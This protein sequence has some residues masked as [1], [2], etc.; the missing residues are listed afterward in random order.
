MGFDEYIARKVSASRDLTEL[1]KQALAAIGHVHDKHLVHWDLKGANLLIGREGVVKLMDLGNARA[2]SAEPHKARDSARTTRKNLPPELQRRASADHPSAA[3]ESSNRVTV[4]FEN[5]ENSWDLPA[6]DLYCFAREVNRLIGSH[7]P[8]L[9]LDVGVMDGDA[10]A[11]AVQGRASLRKRLAETDEGEYAMRFV[12]LVLRRILESQGR[13]LSSFYLDAGGVQ[14]TVARLTPAFGA[15]DAIPELQVVPQHVARVPPE[16]NIPWT[17]RVNQLANSS[18]IQRLGR[19]RQLA[20]AHRVYPGAEHTRWEHSIGT[21][22]TAIQ[23]VRALYADRKGVLFRADTSTLDVEALLVAALLHDVGH[24]AFGHQLEESPLIDK[25]HL[26]ESYG[27]LLLESVIQ[28]MREA[29]HLG[30]KGATL[31][32]DGLAESVRQQILRDADELRTVL[33]QAWAGSDRDRGVALVG[34]ALGI[35]KGSEVRSW[36]SESHALVNRDEAAAAL[37]DVLHSIINGPL[38]ADKMD[39]L[40]RDGVHCGVSYPTGIDELRFLQ[41]LTTVIAPE[42]SS[43]ASGTLGGLAV[44][45]KGILPL[46]SFV[47]AR[48]QM[49][50]SIYWHRTVRALTAALLFV[51]EALVVPYGRGEPRKKVLSMLLGEARDMHDDAFVTWLLEQ[52]QDHQRNDGTQ[53]SKAIEGAVE[54]VDGIAGRRESIYWSVTSF[55]DRGRDTD[56]SDEVYRRLRTGW[57]PEGLQGF[58]LIARR[59]EIRGRLRKALVRSLRD[60]GFRGE[61]SD[62]DVL[63]DVPEP[64]RDQVTGLY[65]E[66]GE[67][68]VSETTPLQDLTPISGAVGE[69][70]ARSLRWARVFVRASKGREIVRSGVTRDRLARLVNE[71]VVAEVLPGTGAQ[72]QM[73][74]AT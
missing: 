57:W 4:A 40:K 50:R 32:V 63:L 37:T 72:L 45:K 13:A 35:L 10:L 38:D 24:P 53:E 52:L 66:L 42:P 39:Y 59:R 12:G 73:E 67:Q 8:T 47:V 33:L 28:L 1:V 56:V 27:E 68:G 18:P 30:A 60:L 26:H 2:L 70:F 36:S 55:Y 65:V 6:L 22:L 69:A 16:E 43:S 25:L 58:K 54:A 23:Y 51:L 49:F 3:P 21:L 41:S 64:G 46:E 14:E 71:V 9:Q 17:D 11:A 15:A 29:D 5:G 20:T 7:E 62:G 48:Y 19:H 31:E 74:L 44:S 34:R 61:L